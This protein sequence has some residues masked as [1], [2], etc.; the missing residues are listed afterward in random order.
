MSHGKERSRPYYY[1]AYI[2]FNLVF[3]PTSMGSLFFI[4]LFLPL[5]V[6]VVRLRW[7]GYGSVLVRFAVGYGS[8]TVTVRLF[9][10]R[11]VNIY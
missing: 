7:F 11:S 8:V 9:S 4:S 6:T 3:H 1:H 2:D 10:V 5:E